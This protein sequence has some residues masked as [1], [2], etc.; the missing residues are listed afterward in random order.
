MSRLNAFLSEIKKNKDLKVFLALFALGAF[1]RLF[2]LDLQSPWED[3]LFSIRASSESSLSN[4]WGWMK[5]D[6]HPPLYQ[7]LLYFWFQAFGPTIFVGRML[8]AIAGLLV[9]LAFFVFAPSGLSGR[10]KVSVSALLALSTGLI[11]YS[12]ELRS[13]SLLIL[14]C[15]IQLACVLRLSYRSD[16]ETGVTGNAKDVP[17]EANQ[18]L[19]TY[20]SILGISLLASYTHFFGFI[21]SASV[22]L[23][24]FIAD[25]IFQRK[26]PKISFCFGILFAVLFLPALYLL[27][28][29]NKIGIASWIPEAG[30]TAFVVFFDLVFHSGI[31][32]KFIPGI[33]ASLA[34]L[35]GFASL[36][37]QKK[38]TDTESVNLEPADKRSAI[39]LIVILIV[40]TIVLGILS[41][42][43][44][45]ITARNLLVT[46]PALYFL[47]TTGFS[48]FP[49]YKGRRL[50]SI[51]ILISLVSLYYFT[52]YY[53]KPYKEQWRE[54]SGYILSKIAERPK[55]FTLLCS[56]HTYN[57]EYFLKTAKIEGVTPK[58]YSKEEADLFIKDPSRKDL[59]ILETSWKYLNM[60]EVDTLFN[61]NTF[62]RTDQLFYGMKVIVLRKK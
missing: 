9:P 55:E 8:S 61:R 4:L 27:F 2:R 53:Y 58:I 49:I 23:G 14:F 20:W 17:K 60:E 30:F 7:T 24:I 51:L 34:L 3:E 62:D 13:Y 44:P 5:N 19:G 33:V 1:F 36:Y 16:V 11:Y 41:A 57:M 35:V 40:F 15:T 28:N 47:I 43:Q 56:S 46:A 37:F 22:F 12:Q 45:L 31:L 29:S 26:F 6:P 25:W 54:S 10:I 42:I 48:L 38:E 50:E 21:W 39:S 18:N 59:V 52:R 32:K